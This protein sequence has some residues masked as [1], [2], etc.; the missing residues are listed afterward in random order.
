MR[1]KNTK[2]LLGNWQAK[3]LEKHKSKF[4]NGVFNKKSPIISLFSKGTQ[5]FIDIVEP[6]QQGP[7]GIPNELYN[8]YVR[9]S[10]KSYVKNNNSISILMEDYNKTKTKVLNKYA[11][12]RHGPQV[13]EPSILQYPKNLSKWKMKSTPFKV[14]Q[15]QFTVKLKLEKKTAKKSK[16]SL[17]LDQNVSFENMFMRSDKLK[18]VTKVTA[19]STSRFKALAEYTNNYGFRINNNTKWSKVGSIMF[20]YDTPQGKASAIMKKKRTTNDGDI[21]IFDIFYPLKSNMARNQKDLETRESKIVDDFYKFITPITHGLK[22]TPIRP[23]P[24][25]FNNISGGYSMNMKPLFVEKGDELPENYIDRLVRLAILPSSIQPKGKKVRKTRSNKV[26][27]RTTYR[28]MNNPGQELGGKLYEAETFYNYTKAGQQKPK[29]EENFKGVSYI[30]V[31]TYE[32]KPA[33]TMVISYRDGEN[34]SDMCTDIQIIGVRGGYQ[35]LHEC[36]EFCKRFFDWVY[37]NYK[38]LM[39]K[40]VKSE[41]AHLN[42]NKSECRDLKTKKLN[43]NGKPIEKKRIRNPD[44]GRCVLVDGAIGRR[45]LGEQRSNK[46]QS[47]CSIRPKP[48]NFATGK[49]PEGYYIRPNK[50]GQPCCYKIPKTRTYMKQH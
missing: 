9:E 38:P 3:F 8:D 16:F 42:K 39:E 12:S 10:L 29:E 7:Q 32:G 35:K 37:I 28:D 45:I 34:K 4:K 40:C 11:K 6:P 31:I 18:K 49:C 24:V 22:I 25:V 26:F 1:I 48:Y 23:I 15:I 21:Y 44:T 27:T 47:S 2:L 19:Q 41:F 50:Q 14:N 43:A 5:K 17:S 36:Y 20:Q 30:K 13:V 46:T 33:F